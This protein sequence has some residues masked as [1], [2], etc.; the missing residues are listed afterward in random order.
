M[1]DDE[2]GRVRLAGM[3]DGISLREGYSPIEVAREIE[4]AVEATQY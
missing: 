3:P 2:I 4:E 1:I